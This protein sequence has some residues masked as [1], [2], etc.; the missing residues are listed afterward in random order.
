MTIFDAGSLGNG[1]TLTYPLGETPITVLPSG[2]TVMFDRATCIWYRR[3]RLG[4]VAEHIRNPAVRNFCRQEWANLLEGLFLNSAARFVNPVFAEYAA[5]KPRQLHVAREVGWAIPDTLITSDEDHASAFIQKH[6]G[7]V[8]HKAMTAPRDRLID[9]RVWDE[10]DRPALKALTFA[11]TIFQEMICG[12]M[13]LRITVVGQQV[14]TARI[15]TDHSR[16]GIDSRMDMDAPYEP[17]ELPDQIHERVLAFM[18][19]M[20]L[21]YGTIDLK[22]TPEGEYVFLEVNPQGQFLYVEILTGMPIASAMADLLAQGA[23][24]SPPQSSVHGSLS[25]LIHQNRSTCDAHKD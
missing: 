3:P 7:R 10:G 16:A 11:P 13:D 24:Q 5:V 2:Q 8:I 17:Y 18:A 21:V 6:R 4:H 1:S 15:L 19:A 23:D 9:T 22:I 25:D 14:F 12:P 20:E